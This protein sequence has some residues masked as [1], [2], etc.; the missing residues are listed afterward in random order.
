MPAHTQRGAQDQAHT[1]QAAACREAARTQAWHGGARISGPGRIPHAVTGLTCAHGYGQG[2]PAAL[3]AAPC[4][5]H[6]TGVPVTSK[7]GR[8]PGTARQPGQAPLAARRPA[9]P[10]RALGPPHLDQANASSCMQS[11]SQAWPH[12][13]DA[14]CAAG[15]ASAVRGLQGRG[16]ARSVAGG[17]GRARCSALTST[18]SCHVPWP[19]SAYVQGA[20]VTWSPSCQPVTPSPTSSMTPM[21]AGPPSGCV[22]QGRAAAPHCM[23]NAGRRRMPGWPAGDRMTYAPCCSLA[24][25][26]RLDD[27]SMCA[28][29]SCCCRAW[30]AWH[31]AG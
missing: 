1:P 29:F 11:R 6:S 20:A 26:D 31:H 13:P 24:G 4:H 12:V 17:P 7:L 30:A 15:A 25:T 8:P 23:A 14:R 9:D 16:C 10:Q 21:P 28:V 22:L 27:I 3:S 5:I 18:Y 19:S 2:G